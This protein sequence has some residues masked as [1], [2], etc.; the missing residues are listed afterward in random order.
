MNTYLVIITTVLVLTQVIRI[1]QNTISLHKH[2][3]MI[4]AELNRLGNISNEDI[5][6]QKEAYR[7]IVSRLRFEECSKRSDNNAQ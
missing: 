5:E 3:K 2:N 7:L 1:V 6:I 4:N